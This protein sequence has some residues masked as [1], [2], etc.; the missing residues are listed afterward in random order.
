[1][2]MILRPYQEEDIDF[3]VRKKRALNAN[4]PGLG[5]TLET[6]VS[7]HRLSMGD[8]LVISPKMAT[9]VWQFEAEQWYNWKGI[10]ITGEFNKEERKQ[11]RRDFV[12]SSTH[13]MLINFAMLNEIQEWRTQWKTVIVDEAHL[14]GLLNHKSV[15]FK[16][17]QKL[18]SENLFILTGTPVRRGPADLWPILHLLDKKRFPAYWPFVNKYCHVVKGPFGKEILGMPKHPTKF[19]AMLG[20][21]MIRHKKVDV[22]P[23]LP[24]KQRQPVPIDMLEKQQAAYDELLAEMMLELP[25][26]DVLL[27]PTRLTQDLRLR[28]ML[29]CP[30][31][32]GLDYDGAAI[33]YLTTYAIPEEFDS[34]RSIVI[35]TPFR[36]AIPFIEEA[37][38]RDISNVHLE[39]IHGQ[40]KETAQ[41]VAQ[42]FQDH[43]NK[44]K[45]L[46]YTIKS[47][48]SWTAHQASTGFM[49]GYEWSCTDQVQAEDRIHRIGQ[50][51]KVFW[52]YILHNNTIDEAVMSRLDQK[53][54][55]A[56]WIYTPE[57]IQKYLEAA[58]E[59]YFKN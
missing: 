58:R 6:L 44:R 51:E 57:E 27:T 7:R 53:H 34:G 41:E 45:I 54:M 23:D 28:Q 56:T 30:R 29:V 21:Y 37:I 8:T 47:G 26:G 24:P 38:R 10:R 4:E 12:E 55:S 9:G 31:L 18:Q 19:K 3:M 25:D 49:L 11:L 52:K 13:I 32:I 17:M 42:R 59:N 48:A 16:L 2:E 39:F 15:T 1:M 5:K 14:G 46:I 43:P 22:L 40:I 35:A 50:E 36:Q 33:E 20:E